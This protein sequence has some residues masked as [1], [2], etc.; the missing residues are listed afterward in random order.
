MPVL[1]YGSTRMASVFGR[2]KFQ[3]GKH[4]RE[5]ASHRDFPI[6]FDDHINCITLHVLSV[7][8]NERGDRVRKFFCKKCVS[9]REM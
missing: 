8:V 9:F 6:I 7:L 5:V 4:I 3:R 2:C 1:G